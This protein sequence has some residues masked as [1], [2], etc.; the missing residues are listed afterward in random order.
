MGTW[1][2]GWSD[3]KNL[4]WK[5]SGSVWW[6]G[7]RWKGKARTK[8]MY[9]A[10][11][12][13]LNQKG[14]HGTKLQW[15][16]SSIHIYSVKSSGQLCIKPHPNIYIYIYIYSASTLL[17]TGINFGRLFHGFSQNKNYVRIRWCVFG[18]NCLV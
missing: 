15:P 9:G 17:F 18:I 8:H 7:L 16:T 14:D 10:F 11:G 5:V 12:F 6:C 4:E 13:D 2:E 3:G 1:F